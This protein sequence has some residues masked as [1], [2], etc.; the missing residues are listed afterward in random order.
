MLDVYQDILGLR[1]SEINDAHTWHRDVRMFDVYDRS[2]NAFM[3]HFYLGTALS[4][5][6]CSVSCLSLTRQLPVG[7]V[8]ARPMAARGQVHPRGRLPLG[9]LAPLPRRLGFVVSPRHP[10]IVLC[11]APA[12]RPYVPPSCAADECPYAVTADLRD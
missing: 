4:S 2:T 8:N 12:H 11:S 3:G 5:L 10:L 9:A 1:F 6:P 7:G